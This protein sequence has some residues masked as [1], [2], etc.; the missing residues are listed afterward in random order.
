MSDDDQPKSLEKSLLEISNNINN[1][2]FMLME[3]LG[4]VVDGCRAALNV[5]IE[6]AQDV[7]KMS[8]DDFDQHIGSVTDSFR[9]LTI[10]MKVTDT[11]EEYS[12][13][14]D[15]GKLSVFDECVEP[16]VIIV[17]D[18]G[19]LIALF[20]SDP[21]LSL[22]DVLETR[23]K[24]SGSDSLDVVECLGFLCYPSLLRVAQS[25]IDPTSILS[26]DADSMI[27]VAASDLVVKMIRKWI[28]TQLVAPDS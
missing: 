7:N 26:E 15:K 16:D 23:L 28:D 10:C 20:N 13:V 9:N 17:S 6:K 25:G 12:V 8:E 24:L 14:F 27:M 21:Q 22:P 19:T 11:K 18:H 2:K 4:P 1:D 5:S 3:Y